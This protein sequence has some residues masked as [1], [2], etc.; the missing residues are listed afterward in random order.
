[1]DSSLLDEY[2][3]KLISSVPLSAYTTFQLGGFCRGIFHCQHPDQL[4]KV[5]LSLA[6][7]KENFILIGGGSNIVVSDEGVDC[8]VIR[9]ASDITI[10]QREADDLIVSGSTNL[11]ALVQ[12][13][14]DYGLEGLNYASG[15]PGTVGGAIV[16]N[17]GA[18]GQQVGDVLQSALLIA[19]DTEVKEV[20]AAALHFSYRHSI[21]KETGDIVVSVRFRLKPGEKDRLWQQREDILKLRRTKHPDLSIYPCAGSFFRNVEP[22]SNAG[23]RQAAGWFLDQAGGKQL[24]C[25]GASIFPKHANIIIKG[26]KCKAQDVYELS[27]QMFDRVKDKFNLELIREVRFM[28]KFKGMPSDGTNYIW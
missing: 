9:Y 7:Q 1:M 22:T 19:R 17:A 18:F 2:N 13:A 6:R 28:G 16:G 21:L 25:G 20:N 4:Q 12:I 26:E 27:Q 8:Y 3:V 15:I 24:R 23:Q 14:A 10:V 5:I 11:D